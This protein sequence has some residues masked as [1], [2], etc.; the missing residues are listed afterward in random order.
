MLPYIDL[1][2]YDVKHMNSEK[3]EALAGAGNE[4]ILENLRNI[5][6]HGKPIWIRVPLIPGYNDSEENF[7]QIAEFVKP[8]KSVEKVTLL[9]YNEAAGAK[10]EFTGKEYELEHLVPHSKEKMETFLEIF[11]DLGVQAELGR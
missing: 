4:L 3:H 1:F 7:R 11:S 8:L 10:Y 6:Q 2:L 5:S 9:P